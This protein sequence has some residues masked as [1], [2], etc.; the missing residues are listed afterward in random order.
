MPDVKKVG[1]DSDHDL[2]FIRRLWPGATIQVEGIL[3]STVIN[4]SEV[5]PL[6]PVNAVDFRQDS[7]V[8]VDKYLVLIL[9]AKKPPS[10]R[11]YVLLAIPAVQ[12]RH[13]GRYVVCLHPHAHRMWRREVKQVAAVEVNLDLWA[14][15]GVE[16][17]VSELRA[18]SKRSLIVPCQARL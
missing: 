16:S 8:G 12:Q 17:C 11:I 1:L 10:R 13:I 15:V 14:R 7:S 6:Q 2:T 3:L 9:G 5:T 4:Q 18:G